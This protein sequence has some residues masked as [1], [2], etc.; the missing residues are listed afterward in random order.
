MLLFQRK[1]SMKEILLWRQMNQSKGYWGSD[2]EKIKV[3]IEKLVFDPENDDELVAPYTLPEDDLGIFINSAVNNLDKEL[4]NKLYVLFHLF[5][6]A[7]SS[8]PSQKFLQSTNTIIDEIGIVPYKNI[9]H[10]FLEQVIQLKE[11]E[12][13][14]SN[15]WIT[16]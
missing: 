9:V 5:L 3:K 15:G 7:S 1:N 6:K 11:K 8:K 12:I 4:R 10:I 16:H 13:R 14:H 2:I